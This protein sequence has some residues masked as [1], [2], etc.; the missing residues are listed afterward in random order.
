MIKKLIA[1]YGRHFWLV[2]LAV[3]VY[4]I[5]EGSFFDILMLSALTFI[6]YNG[7]HND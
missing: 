3:W 2:S 5:F 4:A 6:F 7:G 1:K